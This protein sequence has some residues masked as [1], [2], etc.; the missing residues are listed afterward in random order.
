[1]GPP[2]QPV[3]GGNDRLPKQRI[4]ARTKSTHPA[5]QSVADPLVAPANE[6]VQTSAGQTALQ[7]WA[8]PTRRAKLDAHS[9]PSL[10]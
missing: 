2:I 10:M 3:L 7:A 5:P 4:S 6:G 8:G 1:M 9:I